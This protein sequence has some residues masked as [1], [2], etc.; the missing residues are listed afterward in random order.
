MTLTARQR[1]V[2]DLYA[3]GMLQKEIAAELGVTI[4]T[5]WNTLAKARLNYGARNT[6]HLI[7]L[8]AGGPPQ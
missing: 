6:R 3:S 1:Q 7:Q 4:H 2:V 8:L 5:V